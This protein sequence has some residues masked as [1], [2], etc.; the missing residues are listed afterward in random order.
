MRPRDDAPEVAPVVASRTSTYVTLFVLLTLLGACFAVMMVARGSEHLPVLPADTLTLAVLAVFLLV[1]E[2]QTLKW[3]RLHDGGE[4]T[5][6]WAFAFSIAILP[7]PL[8]AVGMLALASALADS[9][10]R[11]PP[12]RI[13]FN[14]AQTSLSLSAGILVLLWLGPISPLN[15]I[16]GWGEVRW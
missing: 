9:F 6:S 16:Q 13:V 2:L 11:K 10:H 8:F 14:V 7:A 4:I 1:G 3:L 5:P 15:S 12:I